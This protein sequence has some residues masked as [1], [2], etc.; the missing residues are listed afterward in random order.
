[1]PGLPGNS[2]LFAARRRPNLYP[3]GLD[4]GSLSLSCLVCLYT[5]IV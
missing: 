5:D 3:L 4:A 1:M 2:E